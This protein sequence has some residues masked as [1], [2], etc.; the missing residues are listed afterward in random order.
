MVALPG[1][2]LG[3][4]GAFSMEAAGALFGHCRLGAPDR[5]RVG[6]QGR[7]TWRERQLLEGDNS[8]DDLT[9]GQASGVSRASQE[10]ILSRRR[11]GRFCRRRHGLDTRWRSFLISRPCLLRRQ[12][13]RCE[14]APE[15]EYDSFAFH[16]ISS[17]S[18]V[19]TWGSFRRGSRSQSGSVSRIISTRL[20][21]IS[22]RSCG[23]K[24]AV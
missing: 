1:S 18:A 11:S 10:T 19:C 15:Q 3:K 21:A 16:R 22:A 2:G 9:G 7:E 13:Y 24:G 5:A 8:L 4:S 23:V 14:L 12:E 6:P 20:R 17:T